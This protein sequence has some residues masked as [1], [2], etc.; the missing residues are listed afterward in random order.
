MKRLNA[1]PKGEY[2]KR[3]GSAKTVF[4]KG[5][6]DKKTKMFECHDTE[7]MNRTVWLKATTLV[8]T[9]FTY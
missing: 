5:L 4:V 6:Y 7:D 9:E 2:F 1:L 3:K 8:S